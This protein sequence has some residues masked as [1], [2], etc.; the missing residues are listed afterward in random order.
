MCITLYNNVG[1]LVGE[2]TCHSV[3]S[4]LVLGAND[5]LGDTH[6][7]VHIS[8]IHSGV[9]ISHEA[10]YSLIAWPIK[11]VHCRG[12]SLYDHEIRDKFNCR[13]A[14]LLRPPSLTSA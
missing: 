5:P 7:A 14:S 10:I 12:A 8:K 9:D 1:T 2:G 6:V 4:D 13:Q 11:L 3:K